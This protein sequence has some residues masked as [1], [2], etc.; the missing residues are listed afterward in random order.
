MC[1][2]IYMTFGSV[3]HLTYRILNLE[4]RRQSLLPPKSRPESVKE[5]NTGVT[6]RDSGLR[7]YR[8]GALDRAPPTPSTLL[9]EVSLLN[10]GST[11]LSL[12]SQVN[13]SWISPSRRT[14]RAPDL[15]LFYPRRESVTRRTDR[16][17]RVK[18]FGRFLVVVSLYDP[19]R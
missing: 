5:Q 9:Y 15:S 12:G 4:L 1:R 8:V 18:E 16:V 17:W 14:V 11:R 3:T 2:D 13:V 7:K 10:R 19:T 6:R